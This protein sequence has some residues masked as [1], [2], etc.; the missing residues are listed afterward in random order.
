M[1]EVVRLTVYLIRTMVRKDNKQIFQR[2]FICLDNNNSNNVSLLPFL[3][4]AQ[5]QMI[6]P[7]PSPRE[8]FPAL[9]S[10]SSSAFPNDNSYTD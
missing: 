1:F 3:E 5:N 7:P 9:P 6:P 8:L 2:K 4:A 10:F